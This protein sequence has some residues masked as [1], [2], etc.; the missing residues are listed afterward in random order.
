M[1]ATGY[2]QKQFQLPLQIRHWSLPLVFSL[3]LQP[4]LRTLDSE[5]K[6]GFFDDVTWG[7]VYLRANNN[8]K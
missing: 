8:N 1:F 7:A 4:V 5:F 2:S 6:I 3:S